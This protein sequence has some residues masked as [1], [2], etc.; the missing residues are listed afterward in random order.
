MHSFGVHQSGRPGHPMSSH[1]ISWFRVG[2][3][4]PSRPCANWYP[5]VGLVLGGRS[6]HPGDYRCPSG[7][8]PPAQAADFRATAPLELDRAG[9]CCTSGHFLWSWFLPWGVFLP[10][11]P[12]PPLT[13]F[14]SPDRLFPRFPALGSLVRRLV[15]ARYAPS[16]ASIRI[17]CEAPL[18]AW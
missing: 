16:V 4:H 12:F 15:E 13:A 14:S 1:S 18:Y 6:A 8:V 17:L 3:R 10:S 7:P 9:V 5:A 2:G 11:P